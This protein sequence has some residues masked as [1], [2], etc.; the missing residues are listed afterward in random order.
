M[1]APQAV[2][3]VLPVEDLFCNEEMRTFS[4][5]GAHLTQTCDGEKQSQLL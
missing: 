1:V 4:R 5:I 3:S 2:N